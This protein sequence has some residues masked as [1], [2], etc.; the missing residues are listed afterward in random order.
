MILAKFFKIGDHLPPEKPRNA[1]N[2]ITAHDIGTKFGV[3]VRL[4]MLDLPCEFRKPSSK[5]LFGAQDPPFFPRAEKTAPCQRAKFFHAPHDEKRRIFG[6]HPSNFV[7]TLQS[8]V[9]LRAL[10][11]LRLLR[12]ARWEYFGPFGPSGCCAPPDGYATSDF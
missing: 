10:R 9:E 6:F 11:A 8:Y 7:L 4:M 1:I 5:T 12:P 3:S 2:S